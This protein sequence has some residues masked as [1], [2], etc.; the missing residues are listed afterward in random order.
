MHIYVHISAVAPIYMPQEALLS[1]V[2][3]LISNIIPNKTRR[4]RV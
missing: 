3:L 2:M 4:N 1:P